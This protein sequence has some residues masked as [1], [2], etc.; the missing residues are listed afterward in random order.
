MTVVCWRAQ[1]KATCEVAMARDREDDGLKEFDGDFS[2]DSSGAQYPRFPCHVCCLARSA[3]I[4]CILAE[5]QGSVHHSFWLHTAYCMCMYHAFTL[6]LV[7]N[8]ISI[9]K[10][11]AQTISEKHCYA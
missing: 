2:D 5:R 3:W 7:R 8:M 4:R 1:A 10:C 6:F 11:L 9:V